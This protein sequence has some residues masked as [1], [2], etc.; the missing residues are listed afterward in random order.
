MSRSK[1]QL[2]EHVISEDS[3]ESYKTPQVLIDQLFRLLYL[4]KFSEEMSKQ[5]IETVLM[6]GSETSALSLSYTILMLAMHPDVQDRLYDEL[7]S[8]FVAQ[9]EETTYEHLKCLTYLDRIVKEVQ[10]LFPAAPL[11]ARCATADIPISNCTIPKSAFIMMSIFNMHRVSIRS[12]S[13]LILNLY[14][15]S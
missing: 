5:Q 1:A 12:Y 14:I 4:G 10:R 13:H 6:A 15:C 7:H 11:I 3:S 2:K 9:D 8:V